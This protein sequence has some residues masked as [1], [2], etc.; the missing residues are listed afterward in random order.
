MILFTAINDHKVG[1]V[2]VCPI[3]AQTL[4]IFKKPFLQCWFV[5]GRP[6]WANQRCAT[7]H[8]NHGD[9]ARSDVSICGL[10]RSL[11][12]HWPTNDQNGGK[13]DQI[14]AMW[15]Q[16]SQ[17][18]NLRQVH[19]NKWLNAISWNF[20]RRFELNS[21]FDLLCGGKKQ[22]APHRKQQQQL[23]ELRS[24]FA[25]PC[26]G[27]IASQL[28]FLHPTVHC[29]QPVPSAALQCWCSWA[30]AVGELVELEVPQKGPACPSAPFETA[31]EM[32][33]LP[34]LASS[35][36]ETLSAMDYGWRMVKVNSWTTFRMRIQDS[37]QIH[38]LQGELPSGDV[39]P[40]V[41][42]PKSQLFFSLS[43]SRSPSWFF[44][45]AQISTHLISIVKDFAEGLVR[46]KNQVGM[47]ISE[48]LAEG[49]VVLLTVEFR[50]LDLE[51]PHTS[52]PI[53]HK[54]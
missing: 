41:S 52:Y 37:L 49:Q 29:S 19:A 21:L 15:E 30:Y 1:Y 5:N 23:P 20:V 32:P 26:S 38:V 51:E 7:N 36:L 16:T 14:G 25:I 11:W 54:F 27:Y 17:S 47:E 2:A 44:V 31:P 6:P 45:L 8:S 34:D 50:E 18:S 46:S 48:Q 53:L 33:T 3:S 22:K 13:L 4:L 39:L 43:L 10:Q 24:T 40:T 9:A 28:A 12:S 35:I 42:F